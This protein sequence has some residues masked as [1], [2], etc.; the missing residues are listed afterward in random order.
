MSL[1]L[2]SHPDCLLHENFAGHPESPQRL[3]AINDQLIASGVDVV[4]LPADAP[5]ATREQLTRAHSE[6]YV[7]DVFA[8]APE[9]G[10]IEL[11][12]DTFMNSNSLQAALR[13]A[14]AGIDAVDRLFSGKT[15][16]AFCSVRPPGHHAGKSFAM[17]FCI[18]NNIAIAAAHALEEHDL[19]RVAIVDFD[20]HHGN[21]TENIFREDSRVLLCS[22]FQHPFYPYT[23]DEATPDHIVN[24]PLAAGTARADF[25]TKVTETFIPRLHEFKPQLILISAG[26]DGHLE[27]EMADMNLTEADYAWIT[28][29]IKKIADTYAEGRMVSFLEGGYSLSALGRSVVAHLKALME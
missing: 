10:T 25:R 27:D 7:D 14:G 11:A 4:L 15:Q 29:E 3:S 22:S 19:E 12:E 21:G 1:T 24:L 20:V 28:Q 16:S 2:I 9:Q 26:F 17:G 8:R 13:A 5:L 23:G 18:F 6:A